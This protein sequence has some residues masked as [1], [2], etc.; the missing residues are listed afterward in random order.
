MR[1]LAEFVM[2]GRPQAIGVCVLG[3]PLPLLHL[4]STSV[5]SL[6][7]LRKGWAEG[8]LVVA[9]T[10]L[11]LAA[12]YTFSGDPG[13]IITLI[14]TTV[15]AYTL[16]TTIS[17]QWVLVASVLVSG[18]GAWI[19]SVTAA[20]LLDMWVEWY[21]ELTG[22]GEDMENARHVLTGFFAMG[23]AYVM[24]GL[25]V[26][27]RWWQSDLYNPGGF[28]KEFQA[29]RLSPF[30][31]AGIVVLVIGCALS[32]VPELARWLPVLTVPLVMAALGLAHWAFDYNK[33]STGWVVGFYILLTLVP[34]LV[35][36]LLVAGALMDSGLDFR[37]RFQNN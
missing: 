19:F 13:P 35:Y 9:W 6:V 14:G 33:L 10:C 29:L 32:D 5:A 8:L 26:L 4:L 22:A 12:V 3:A 30:V 1:A 11:P 20:D 15:L 28:G 21:R 23:Q 27:A 24:L 17:W 16:R 34:Q 37:R 18:L 7:L 31:A 2:R 25:L 36:P